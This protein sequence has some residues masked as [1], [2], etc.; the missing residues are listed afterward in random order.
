MLFYRG[1]MLV[2]ANKISFIF[3]NFQR[4]SS[5]VFVH[6]RESSTSVEASMWKH[7]YVLW[8]VM[9]SRLNVGTVLEA[10]RPSMRDDRLSRNT[11]GWSAGGI[12]EGGALAEYVRV[13]RWRNEARRGHRGADRYGGYVLTW[14][15]YWDSVMK[16]S[17]AWYLTSFDI[18]MWIEPSNVIAVQLKPIPAASTYKWLF[19][20]QVG[21]VVYL[22]Q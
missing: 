13:E 16:R 17:D 10:P 11:W 21:Y 15:T 12:C 3:G 14:K 2:I 6:T 19:W 7:R 1:A 22:N 5:L 20:T 9:Y 4:K 18:R 8:S